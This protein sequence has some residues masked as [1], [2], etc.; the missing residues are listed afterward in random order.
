MASCGE[1]DSLDLGLSDPGWGRQTRRNA[2][3]EK[4]VADLQKELSAVEGELKK[5]GAAFAKLQGDPSVTL[6]WPEEKKKLADQ[7][8]RLDRK[9]LEDGANVSLEPVDEPSRIERRLT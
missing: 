2:G 6:A 8:R 4:Q 1:Q 7:V 5:K 3:L 9:S